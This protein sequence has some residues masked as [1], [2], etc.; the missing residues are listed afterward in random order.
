MPEINLKSLGVF[1]GQEHQPFFWQAGQP[2]ALLVHGFMGTPAEMRP[3]GQAFQVA[4]W[5][6][7]GLLLPG[8]GRQLDSL[9]Q[10][11]YPEW[12]EAADAALAALQAQHWP[13][14][15]VGYSMGAAVA[16]NVAARR[17]PSGVILVA[18]FWRVGTPIQRLIYQV[19]KR[20]FRRPQ[21]FKKAD[22]ADP[23]LRELFAG[24][25]PD[26]NLDDPTA[27]EAIRQL[28]VPASFADQVFAVGKAAGRAAAR[29][30]APALI[31][32][33]LEDEAVRPAATRQL[34]QSLSGPVQYLELAADHELVRPERPGF[35]DY[36][37]A[38]MRFALSLSGEANPS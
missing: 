22:F 24:L 37:S 28:R 6:V 5:T 13:V 31:I 25:L 19:L 33:G 2:A 17:P 11:R 36:R 14:V 10:R 21:P 38:A 26:L 4:G 35:D 18:P 32:Q 15:L 27:Q 3:L 9:F 29:V 8:F 20:I 23:R 1:Q 7:Q 30:S 12:I 34:L 16:L